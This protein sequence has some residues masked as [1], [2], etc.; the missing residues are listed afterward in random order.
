MAGITGLVKPLVE[1]PPVAAL[2]YGVFAAARVTEVND[3][4]QQARLWGSGYSYL[5][6]HCGGAVAYDDTCAAQPVKEFVEGS[7]LIEGDPFRVMA[8]KQCGAVGRTAAEIEQAVRQQLASGEQSV[9]EAVMWDGSTL[10]AHTPTLTGSG[11]TI[12]TPAAP[13]AGAAIAA[14]EEA[15]YDMFGYQGVIHVNMAAYAALTYPNLVVRDGAVLRTPLGTR[16]SFGSGYGVTG[17][18][19][20]APDAGFVW[21]FMTA[22]V[23]IRRTPVFVPPLDQVF[24]RTNNQWMAEAIRAYAFTWDC[25]EVFAVQVPVAA[26]AV[27][28]APAVPAP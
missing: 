26:P 15:G 12:V 8:T 13:G 25:P 5:T 11:A 4:E 10:A 18:D 17:P 20:A 24:D 28:T 3:Q 14:L 23:D 19:D 1:A 6:D 16:L 7:D 27:A 2:R 9:V 22:M 21:A